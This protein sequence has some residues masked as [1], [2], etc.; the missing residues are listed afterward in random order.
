[1]Q[2][3]FSRRTNSFDAAS[4]A[5]QE[6]LSYTS[7]PSSGLLQ[8]GRNCWRIER[9]HRFSMLVDASAYFRAVRE[10]I[11]A[12]K[13]SIFI[14]SWDIDSR[15]RLIP[16]GARDGFPEPLGDFLHEV[17]AS[18][19]ELHAYVLNWDFAMLYALE[20]E[21][22][23]MYKLDWRTDKRLSF[24]MDGRHPIGASQHQKVV[25]VDDAVAFVGGLDL[26]RSRWDTPEHASNMP[27]RRDPDG[28]PYGPFHDVQALVD[29][30]AARA[31]GELARMRWQRATGHSPVAYRK[32]EHDPWPASAIP[33]I[34]DIDVAISRTEPE[35]DGRAGVHEVRQLHLDAIASARRHMYFEN[36]YFTSGLIGDALSARLAEPEGPEVVVVSPQTQ[37][38]WLED[39]TMGLLR[40][41]LHRRLKEA[42]RY[43]RYLLCCPHLPDLQQ[44]CLNVHSKV[45]S[46]D[47][48]LFCIGS[49]NLSNR[50]MAFDTECNLVIEARGS[51]E[52]KARIRNAIAYLRSRLLAEH[53]GTTVDV[54]DAAVKR[55]NSLHAALATLETNGRTL[56]KFDPIVSPELDSLIAD[57]AVFDPERP[58]DPDELVAQFVAKEERRPVPRRMIGFG[59]VAITLA[60]L[61]IAWRWTPLREWANLG[62]LIAFAK[63]LE[64][65]PF[66]PLAVVASYVVGGLVMM[67]VMLLIAV[68]GIVFGPVYG[69]LYAMGGTLLSATVTYGVGAWLGRDAVRRLLG[70]RINSLSRRIGRRGILAMVIVRT[71]PVAP[72]TVVNVVAGASHIRFRDYLIGTFLGMMPG[73]AITVT[74][75]HHLAETVRNPSIGTISVLIGVVALLIGFA[76][77]LQRLLGGKEN[78]EA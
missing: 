46:I 59:T 56:R 78:A 9:T 3:Y 70:P 22:L 24:R 71:V 48:N 63:S 7:S 72:F 13:H 39:A 11:R 12:A 58:I 67:P 1:M 54:V 33:D 35:F 36:Q 34:T 51:E 14:L 41:R 2:A 10:A 19:P 20:R 44:G 65:L 77:L 47:D 49:A 4:M 74:F 62:S 76:L 15:T 43:G 25:V 17:V 61:A 27:L 23:P 57:Q 52:K 64:N 68:T 18:E 38:G 31:L 55:D 75:V 42:D 45:F 50:S 21:W 73:I 8:P 28:K 53:L 16:D 26:T 5:R 69:T 37:S 66:T 30:D 29:G 32:P 60:L 40:A 6:P